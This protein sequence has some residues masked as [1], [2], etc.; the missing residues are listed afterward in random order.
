[1]L[2]L[3]RLKRASPETSL[4]LIY[5][6]ARD[7]LDHQASRIDALDT[8]G[9]ALLAAASILVTVIPII[10]AP[11]QSLETHSLV[12]LAL[13]GLCYLALWTFIAH[14]LWG[15][16]YNF[17]PDVANLHAGYLD[18]PPAETKAAIAKRIAEVYPDNHATIEAKAA[19]LR[20]ALIALLAQ[21]LL[22]VTYSLW[23]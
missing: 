23:R 18:A 2:G 19:T 16:K 11:N 9:Y 22:L 1:M 10:H 6:I 13:A 21:S 14:A 4:D 20:L 17:P 5:Q 7:R 15:H 3:F 12:L 8:K